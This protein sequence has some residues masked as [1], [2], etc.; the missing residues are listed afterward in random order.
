MLLESLHNKK[1]IK[2]YNIKKSFQNRAAN[3]KRTPFYIISRYKLYVNKTLKRRSLKKMA[4]KESVA[5]TSTK[6]LSL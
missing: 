3:I 1:A 4:K 5:G 6:H 2:L